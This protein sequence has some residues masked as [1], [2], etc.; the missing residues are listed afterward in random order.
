MLNS[1]ID[2]QD[3]SFLAHYFDAFGLNPGQQYDVNFNK[4]EEEEMMN[5]LHMKQQNHILKALVKVL[6]EV[7]EASITIG[8]VSCI[9]AFLANFLTPTVEVLLPVPA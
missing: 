8:S 9:P 7:G 3:P 4:E 5:C 6:L 2:D 1:D